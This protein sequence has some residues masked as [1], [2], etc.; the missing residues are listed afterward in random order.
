MPASFIPPSGLRVRRAPPGRPGQQGVVLIVALVMLVIIGMSSAALMRNAMMADAVSNNTRMEALA[1][2]A[3][4]IALRHCE[5][6]LINNAAGF[7]V[8]PVAAEGQP[9][10][11]QRFANW[12]GDAALAT[13]LTSEEVASD[14]A[15]L[16]YEDG[17]PRL[18]QCLAEQYPDPASPGTHLANTF[19]VT[20]RGFSPD[21][22][23]DANGRRLSGSV[24][25][26]QSTFRTN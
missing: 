21:Y 14:D 20:A 11:W 13:R 19:T 26:L 22:S 1:T 5:T 6:R 12:H 10:P 23:E 25:W 4:Q 8:Q 3:A 2:E 9:Q 15:A 18:P 16:S 24:V 7:A 17:D